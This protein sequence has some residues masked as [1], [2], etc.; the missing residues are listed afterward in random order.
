MSGFRAKRS[1]PVPRTVLVAGFL[2]AAVLTAPATRAADA[3]DPLY[4]HALYIPTKPHRIRVLVPVRRDTESVLAWVRAGHPAVDVRSYPDGVVDL[5]VGEGDYAAVSSYLTSRLDLASDHWTRVWAAQLFGPAPG[6]SCTERL[7]VTSG[8][9]TRRETDCSLDEARLRKAGVRIGRP[10][11]I[12]AKRRA[13][14]R[15]S[16]VL[17]DLLPR[18]PAV[19][20]LLESQHDTLD[21]AEGLHR[22]FADTVTIRLALPSRAPA[23]GSA[24]D[25]VSVR[26]APGGGEID[27]KAF[28]ARWGLLPKTRGRVA[29]DPCRL[30][31]GFVV[32]G[33]NFEGQ[34]FLGR[35]ESLVTS[36]GG[37]PDPLPACGGPHAFL[38]P[39]G[40]VASLKRELPGV[41]S[42][43]FW[44]E[45]PPGEAEGTSLSLRDSLAQEA[46]RLDA[47][48]TPAISGLVAAELE[49]LAPLDARRRQA[50][51]MVSLLVG[52]YPGRR[53][54]Q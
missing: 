7:A 40:A 47:R 49:R 2:A 33:I 20:S 46:R 44:R 48:R 14:A 38:L 8:R 5:E 15:D 28:A 9:Y 12:A 13:L 18:L 52:A 42:N 4:W 30:T 24:A 45:V 27:G 37:R 16:A 36:L 11:E 17:G 22:F 54:P 32:E 39:R 1:G 26:T 53:P 19:A 41:L 6:E 34:A 23:A 51:D 31:G 43:P 50:G 35:L 3:S 21:W 29:V 10:E 25:G